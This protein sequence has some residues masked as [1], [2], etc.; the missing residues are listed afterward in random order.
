M[1]LRPYFAETYA[2]IVVITAA[3]AGACALLSVTMFFF[4]P[5]CEPILRLALPL[6]AEWLCHA[7]V[8]Y[9]PASYWFWDA[10]VAFLAFFVVFLAVTVLIRKPAEDRRIDEA[11]LRQTSQ[12]SHGAPL[13]PE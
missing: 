4:R 5:L 6:F 11:L 3:F 12:L 13:E 10:F 8:A 1:K 7:H 9:D 2:G